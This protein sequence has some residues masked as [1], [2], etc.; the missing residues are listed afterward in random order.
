MADSTPASS[1]SSS[2]GKTQAFWVKDEYVLRCT[3]CDVDF[4]LGTRRHHCRDCGEIFCDHCTQRR[5]PL[6]DLYPKEPTHAQRVCES[7]FTQRT[8][9]APSDGNENAKEEDDPDYKVLLGLKRLYRSG[10]KP[11]ER[12]FRFQDFYSPLLTD[13]DFNQKPMV[14]LVEPTTERFTLVT[15]SPTGQ[16]GIVP[17]NALAVQSDR[18][19]RSLQKFGGAFLSKFECAEVGIK[20]GDEEADGSPKTSLLT[21]LSFVDT[22]GILSGE[23]QRL[24]RSD[25]FQKS[26]EALRGHDEKIRVVLNKAD[27]IDPQQLMR[28]HGALMWSLAPE[29][30]SI[31]RAHGIPIGD[32]PFPD[33]FKKLFELHCGNSIDAFPTLNTQLLS[34]LNDILQTQIPR[35]VAANNE[36]QVARVQQNKLH[37]DNPFSNSDWQISQEQFDTYKTEFESLFPEIPSGFLPGAQA[38]PA[39][40]QVDYLKLYSKK[41]GTWP[42]TTRMENSRWQEFAIAKFL[43]ESALRGT[44]LPDVLP[45]SLVPPR[46]F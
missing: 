33:Q 41:Y 38:R 16:D 21:N 25:E 4:S 46:K 8:I 7:C 43:I 9:T 34:D 39:L 15:S 35:I 45:Q 26:I 44:A 20:D 14:L 36:R 27:S 31:S 12:Q 6:P 32:F 3:S 11:L 19:F 17:G 18:P 42:T 10:I 23:K 5:T 24:G 13:A 1:S 22:P 37:R 2:S 40:M 30:R 28:V 29:F